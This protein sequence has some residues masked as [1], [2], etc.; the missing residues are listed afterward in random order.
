M[1]KAGLKKICYTRNTLQY[2]ERS[3][4]NMVVIFLKNAAQIPNIMLLRKFHDEIDNPVNTKHL[5]NI[6]ATPAQRLRRWSNILIML[7]K[8]VYWEYNAPVLQQTRIPVN[9]KYFKHG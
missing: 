2:S 6:Y 5:Y 3:P 8:C 9:S 7:Y 1:F 4:V